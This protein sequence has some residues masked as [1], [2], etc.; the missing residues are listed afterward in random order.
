VVSVTGV[1]AAGS[2][3]AESSSFKKSS[4]LQI[5]YSVSTRRFSICETSEVDTHRSRA[6]RRRDTFRWAYRRGVD[7]AF[8]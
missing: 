6:D 5:A 7:R 3:V 8:T 2:D 1:V 4:A